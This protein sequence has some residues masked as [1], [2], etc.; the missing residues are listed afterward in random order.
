MKAR[1]YLKLA[2]LVLNIVWHST[3]FIVFA[4]LTVRRY[5]KLALLVLNIVWHSSAFSLFGPVDGQAI[6]KT[7][8]AS[9]EYGLTFIRH[10]N[11]R[12]FAV[13]YRRFCLFFLS[14]M[15]IFSNLSVLILLTL[16]Q[17]RKRIRKRKGSCARF[18]HR[19]G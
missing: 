2:L 17:S 8:T 12:V 7:S 13:V 15:Q 10:I 1:P 14:C 16:T 5:S 6:F 19:G 18:N 9:F 4:R 11:L 3:D